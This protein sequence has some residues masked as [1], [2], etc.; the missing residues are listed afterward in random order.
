MVMLNLVLQQVE[1][2]L[3][4]TAWNVVVVVLQV[5]VQ[6]KEAYVWRI[7]FCS[8]PLSYQL[9]NW[10]FYF[11]D[12]IFSCHISTTQETSGSWWSHQ[13][14]FKPVDAL[15]YNWAAQ[16]DAWTWMGISGGTR[17]KRF[18]M[19]KQWKEQQDMQQQFMMAMR[20]REIAYTAKYHYLIR[21]TSK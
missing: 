3:A 17:E 21:A 4:N 14:K 2:V 8:W 12:I 5:V 18:Q 20:L 15:D 19:D 6:C 9:L 13:G 16:Q 7:C 1:N 10:L 11:C